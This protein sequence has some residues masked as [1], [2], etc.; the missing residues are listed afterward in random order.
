[1]TKRLAVVLLMACIALVN[2]TSAIAA[3]TSG[4]LDPTFGGDGA[5]RV[6]AIT[7]AYDVAIQPDGKIVVAGSGRVARLDRHGALDPTFSGNGVVRAHF[8]V[9]E[10]AIQAD[11]RIVVGGIA[12]R[13]ND[14]FFALARYLPDGS[15]DSS[16]S[17]NGKLVARNVGSIDVY[18]VSGIAIAPSGAIVAA[19]YMDTPGHP[20]MFGVIQVTRRGVL[21]RSFS[22]DG[23]APTHLATGGRRFAESVAVQPDGAIIA[24]GRA[25]DGFA[26]VR[27]LP[28]GSRD[29]SF[30]RDGKRTIGF[31][32]D[33]S[34]ATDVAVQDDGRIVVGGTRHEGG[35][36]AYGHL[37]IA[38]ARC[39]ADGSLDATFAGDGKRTTTL[40]GNLRSFSLAIQSD[41]KIVLGGEATPTVDEFPDDFALARYTS[42]GRLDDSF[43]GDGI[44]VTSF[45][46]DEWINGIALQAND[47]IIAVGPSYGRNFGDAIVARYVP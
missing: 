22:G 2:A 35:T 45:H 44:R 32:G 40:D 37:S 39:D 15:L 26:L 20:Y 4:S 19:A 14:D 28:D 7:E 17:G 8:G 29:P 10:I 25:G 1:M 23:V 13:H 16:F 24:V 47:K 34:G 5:V 12:E 33:W 36:N 31:G 21:D 38:L 6:R 9:Y 41:G 11:G 27:Y 30:A 46:V 3:T 43:A 18:E 42:G